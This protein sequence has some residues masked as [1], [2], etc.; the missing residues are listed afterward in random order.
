M[1]NLRSLA[2]VGLF[3]LVGCSGPAPVDPLKK[4]CEGVMCGNGRCALDGTRP[5]CLCD[6]GFRADGL[7]C[8]PVMQPPADKCKPN[9][10]LQQNRTVCTVVNDAAVCVCDP[11]T[12]DRSG[13]CVPLTKCSP[14]PCTAANQTTCAIVA[15]AA[16]CSCNAGHAPQGTG[17]SADKVFDCANKHTAEPSDPLEPDECPTLAS[18]IYADDM[19]QTGRTI[20]P[21]G[22]ADWYQLAAEPN[23]VYRAAASAAAGLPL[24]VDVY[25]A[26]GVTTIG[27]DHLGSAEPKAHFKALVAGTVYI[28][29]RAFRANDTGG[30]ILKVSDLGIDD[31]ADSPALA[32]PA[33]IGGRLEGDIQFPGDL[34]VVALPLLEGRKYGFGAGPT[35]AGFMT[36][37]PPTLT[38]ELIAEDGT[39]VLRKAQ[40]G[41]SSRAATA[42][43]YYLRVSGGPTSVLG[44]F[45]FDLLDLGPDDHGEAPSEATLI[46][47]STVLVPG[48]FELSGDVDFLS[49]DAQVGHIYSFLC[50][51]PSS[52]YG[53]AVAL[54]DKN[55][56]L[57]MTGNSSYSSLLLVEATQAGRM[58]VR[59][60]QQYSYGQVPVGYQYRFED[61]GLDDYGDDQAS[62]TAVT[63][64]TPTAGRLET[65]MDLDVFSVVTQ[66]NRIYRLTC[67]SGSGSSCYPAVT[68]AA[69]VPVAN[70]SSS[71]QVS[72]ESTGGT[73]YVRIGS[74]Y[75]Q[76]GSYSFVV[77]DL[78]VDDYGDTIT[79]ATALTA[80]S[81]VQGGTL[82]QPG[83]VDVF[84]F[85]AVAPNVYRFTCASTTG[86]PC[87]L[88]L[89]NAFGAVLQGSGYSGTS[90]VSIEATTTATYYV[91]VGSTYGSSSGGY[92][93]SLQNLGPDDFGDDRLT[94]TPITAGGAGVAGTLETPTDVDTFSFTAVAN[95]IYLVTCT[96]SAGSSCSTQV[97]NPLGTI[98][99]NGTGS[100]SGSTV[101]S[102]EAATGGAF[103]V[104][105][106]SGYNW[107][108]GTYAL[109]LVDIGL[110]DH[111][112]TP[113]TATAL[114]VP[115]APT[116]ASLEV[117]GDVDVFSFDAISGRI[118]AFTVA[119]SG[120]GVDLRLRNSAG[121]IVTN[122]SSGNQ[123]THK[124]ATTEKLYVE[125]VLSY[126]QVT[127]YTYALADQGLDDHGDTQATATALTLGVATSGKIE[128]A[129]DADYFS[130]SLSAGQ[131]VTFAPGNSQV[132][133][134]VFTAS[135]QPIGYE[136]PYPT[137]FVASSAGTYFIRVRAYY[138]SS[139]FPFPYQVL[140]Q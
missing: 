132:A 99:A 49:F 135:S 27:F 2:A 70:Q 62:A 137:P 50:N 133:F 55:G 108:A 122:V 90:A 101:A 118:Y 77:E 42:G 73:Y 21:A 32:T 9:P 126:G 97:K 124:A 102:F 64:G 84:S 93:F 138:Q 48:Q 35:D 113:A 54:T 139:G 17:C 106:L 92:T 105:V 5:A 117:F 58:F 131:Q 75:S 39:T 46:T 11:G 63:V 10:C 104:E 53:C 34:D 98:V 43:D 25:S 123:L 19:A 127:T 41:F 71:N 103:V 44:H 129:A 12:Y 115:T 66:A 45:D 89:K 100:G 134:S 91:E 82:E 51:Q 130:I 60:S 26:D 23:H 4:A 16:V 22:D 85:S 47:S 14:N 24:Y 110:D 109:T 61:L 33:A 57:L 6:T 96:A 52:Y 128:F 87:N 94:A 65:A 28:R 69:G 29:I 114:T 83:D 3:L 68:N 78:G 67:S 18:G 7:A 125:V 72:W 31:F 36:P 140:L 107:S 120:Y 40:G 1:S 116:M 38:V 88:T 95:H 119:S 111:G 79:T 56:Q 76:P 15:N 59:L 121:I 13:D 30:Y 74:S 81:M 112:D 80:S 20:N 86:S 37:P 136:S 8:V